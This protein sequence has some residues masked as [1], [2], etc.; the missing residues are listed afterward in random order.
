MTSDKN[1]I[2]HAL[3]GTAGD[4]SPEV[5]SVQIVDGSGDQITTFGGGVQYTEGD[6]DSSITGTAALWEDASN[7]LT[8]VSAAK[9]L[10]IRIGDGTNQ[11]SLSTAGAD[12]GSNTSNRLPVLSWLAGFNGTT[13]DRLRSGLTAAQSAATGFLNVLGMLQYNTTAP[14][15]TNGQFVNPQCGPDGSFKT[16]PGI[17]NGVPTETSVS[18]ATSST[19]ILAANA[20]RT[21]LFIQNQD[22]TNPIFV[23]TDGNAAVADGTCTKI[24]AGGSRTWENGFIPNGA[25]FGIATGGTV[26]T[27]VEEAS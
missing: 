2:Q 19:Q 8:P 22:A 7:T 12:A 13:W 18:V 23:A 15:L 1:Q 14:S 24:V 6:T 4:P 17:Y 21:F 20:N 10:P 26:T 3:V 5:V 9:P 11:A 25:V 16:N 27:H